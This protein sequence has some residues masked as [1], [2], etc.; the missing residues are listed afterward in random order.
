MKNS[1]PQN[2]F[3]SPKNAKVSSG[4]QTFA[5][6]QFSGLRPSAEPLLLTADGIKGRQ[7]RA[8]TFGESRGSKDIST[9]GIN[10]RL[11]TESPEQILNSVESLPDSHSMK[12]DRGDYGTYDIDDGNLSD[13]VVKE[14]M[15]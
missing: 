13:F 15:Y 4:R 14:I 2:Q 10:I 7:G 12:F 6:D 5:H 11:S 1:K 8:L 3:Y 9:R